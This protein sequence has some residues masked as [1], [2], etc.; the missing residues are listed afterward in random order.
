MEL[1]GGESAEQ[2]RQ[3]YDGDGAGNASE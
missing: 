1:I 3:L 2:V